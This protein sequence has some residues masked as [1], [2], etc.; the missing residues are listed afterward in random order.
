MQFPVKTIP[1]GLKYTYNR[2]TIVNQGKTKAHFGRSI[3]DVLTYL[4]FVNFEQ[5]KVTYHSKNLLLY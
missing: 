1:T 5:K 4:N 2:L 3:D